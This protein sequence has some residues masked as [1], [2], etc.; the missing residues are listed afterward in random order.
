M[1]EHVREL[2]MEAIA[3][4]DHGTMS[5]T[6]DFYKAA[7][8][9]GIQPIIGMET[10]VANRAHT[11]KDPQK[12]KGRFHLIILAMNNAGYQNLMKLS[13]IANLDGYYYKPR[14]DHDLLETYNE[15]LIILSGCIG[16]EVGDALRRDQYEQARD[17][18]NWYKSVFGDRYY[19]ELQD[20]GHIWDEQKKVNDGLLRLSKELKIP[21]VL[22]CD[23]H[24]LEHEDQEAHEILLCVQTG[25]VLSD[26]KRMSLKDTP[27]HLTDPKELIERWGDTPE[28]L[29]NTKAIAKRCEVTIELDKIL[30]PRFDTPKAQTEQEYLEELTYTGL[31]E[32][33]QPALA[34]SAPT[35]DAGKIRE[36]AIKNLSDTIVQRAK[37][38]LGVMNKMGYDGYF[39]IVHDFIDWGKK[40]GIVFGP[41]RG[42]AAGSI[43]AYALK[44][45]DLDPLQYDLLFER[46]LN[47]DR[48]SMPDI[49]IDIQDSRRDEVIEYV[50]EKYG[51]DR[52]AHIVTYGTMAAR[53][54]IRDVARVLEVPYSEADRLAKLVPPPIQGRHIPLMKSIVNDP[55]LKVEYASNETSKRVLDLA[56]R[57]EGT[58]RSHGVHAAGVV[59]APDEIVKFAP[60]EMAQKGVVST[61]YA[62]GPVEELGLLKMDFLGLSNLT[63]INNALRIIKK[64]YGKDIDIGTLPL[65][66]PDTYALLGRGDTTGVFQLESGGMKRYLKQL[67]PT[68][69]DD[70]I[71][72]AALYRPGPLTAGLTDAFVRRKNG[73]EEAKVPHPKFQEQLGNTF[74][75]LVYQE[76]VMEISKDVC[77]FTGGEADTLRKAI[78]KKKRDVMEKMRVKFIDGGVEHGGV[79]RA[80]MEKFWED[81]MGFADYAFN[82]SHSACYALIAYQT[83]YLKAH[84]PDAFMAAL[85]TSDFNDTDRLTIEIAE[86]RT[87]GIEVLQPDVNQ[88][89]G[90]FA[91]VPGDDH[92]VIRYGMNAV[93]NLGRNAVEE[94]VR[95]RKK[96]G[97]FT[98][99]EDFARRVSPR[100]CNKKGWESLAKAGAFDSIEPNRN[101]ILQN[102][103]SI[104]S[105][106][107]KLHKEAASGQTDLFGGAVEEIITPV[108]RLDDAPETPDAEKLQWERELLGIYLSSHPLDGFDD[109]FSENTMP[110]GELTPEHDGKKAVVGGIVRLI[111]EITTKNGSKMAF[112]TLEDKTGEQELII[113]P[114]VY[115]ETSALWDADK[116]LTI[117]GKCS[118]KDRDGV[119]GTELKILV[120]TAAE[121]TRDTLQSYQSTGKA[122]KAP[123]IA[124]QKE[125]QSDVA[126]AGKKVPTPAPRTQK[127]YIRVIDSEDTKSL[128][129]MKQTLDRFTGSVETVIVLDGESRQAIRLPSR[130]DASPE[131]LKEL[132]SIY[133]EECVVLK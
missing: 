74:G 38:E 16:G 117:T 33:Y 23:A 81:L 50:N 123:K 40:Q 130:V 76:Q 90:E 70:I 113:F 49:D 105:Y 107:Q 30:I 58:M 36:F 96:D 61:Q 1:V 7:Q 119:A 24:Y 73:D 9:A 67:K 53:N 4:T 64:V 120:S 60:L 37:Y 71:A 112:V 131:L 3:V 39:L 88:S 129:E 56:I 57:M 124:K 115:T 86:C 14:I 63:I 92:Q 20:H 8:S 94:V 95:S 44:I 101:K 75:V 10:Y 12:D 79:G 122:K 66:D 72:M 77:G 98:S 110:L 46:F 111:K 121:L 116:I 68:V 100:V 91:V 80:V 108:M 126:E 97:A 6:I 41:G 125:K 42:S 82:K 69:F 62:M 133:T 5:G 21:A 29:T 89:F 84:F 28:L 27:L 118:S 132:A 48:I 17:L 2:G 19:L 103:E 106:S 65:D 52:V 127:L 128:Q 78:G 104:L 99:I 32:R 109:Y 55:D 83:A 18:A 114:N 22:T 45:T 31:L 26:P 25:S 35:G 102:L 54:A 34:S 51:V 85:M 87:M 47:P 93:K 13:T 11:D 59:I 43:V 15:G